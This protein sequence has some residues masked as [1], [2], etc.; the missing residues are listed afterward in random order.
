ML[1]TTPARRRPPRKRRKKR[2][3]RPRPKGTAKQVPVRIRERKLRQRKNQPSPRPLN[4]QLHKLQHPVFRKGS[5]SL[6]TLCLD[7]S[8]T[9]FGFLL[10]ALEVG[11]EKRYLMPY[12]SSF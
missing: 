5:A 9:D 11:K 10:R 1:P 7:G 3:R 12:R 4:P 2:P 8:A 6:K